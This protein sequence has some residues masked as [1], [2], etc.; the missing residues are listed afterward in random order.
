VIHEEPTPVTESHAHA[1][2]DARVQPPSV[3]PASKRGAARSKRSSTPQELPLP[4][5]AV[6]AQQPDNYPPPGATAEPPA[7]A[8]DWD[9]IDDQLKALPAQ[10][11]Q[12][13]LPNAPEAVAPPAPEP[14][15]IPE[16]SQEA[17]PEVAVPPEAPVNL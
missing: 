2:R 7:G 14:E 1:A 3:K 16:P 15:P 13:E 4:N 10:E 9:K 17:A 11:P 12:P 8:T 5:A 6:A